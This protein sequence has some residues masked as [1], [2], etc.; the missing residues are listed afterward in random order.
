MHIVTE[1]RMGTW[2]FVLL[3]ILVSSPSIA[4]ES[5]YGEVEG[6][7]EIRIEDDAAGVIYLQVLSVDRQG[8]SQSLLQPLRMEA[9]AE[10][11]HAYEA[12]GFSHGV[13]VPVRLS[14]EGDGATLKWMQPAQLKLANGTS[15]QIAGNHRLL[16]VADRRAAAERYFELADQGLNEAYR[17]LRSRLTIEDFTE[18]RN[19]Q[20]RWLKYRDHYI[21]DDDD[22][23][24]NGPGSIPFMQVKTMRTLQRTAFL[25]AF[26]KP[27]SGGNISGRYSDG[28]DWELRLNEMSLSGRHLFFILNYRVHEPQGPEWPEPILIS[29]CASPTGNGQSWTITGKGNNIDP[30]RDADSALLLEPADDGESVV[31]SRSAQSPSNTRLYRIAELTPAEEPMRKILLRMPARV[32]D[33]TTEGLSEEDKTQLLLRGASGLFQLLELGIN[34]VQVRYPGGEVDL[35]RFPGADGGAVIAVATANGRARSFEMWLLSAATDN[36]VPWSQKLALPQLRGADFFS[37]SKV[38]ANIAEGLWDF[39][40]R[41]DLAEIH[42]AWIGPADRLEADFAVDLIWDGYGFGVG[43]SARIE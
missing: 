22:T 15:V 2:C 33:N 13:S 16:S 38:T 12:V 11:G 30:E 14:L 10:R 9:I 20:R 17:E 23:A 1:C 43:R 5:Y 42:V 41:K 18:L 7:V 4:K 19:N 36:P 26:K 6:G 25:Q 27:L 21:A 28:I 8:H 32:F 3:L 29:G 40:L 39:S 31:I 37:Q 35:R 34:F 24:V